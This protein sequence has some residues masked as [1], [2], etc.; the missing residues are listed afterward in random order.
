MFSGSMGLFLKAQST[1]NSLVQKVDTF[2]TMSEFYSTTE[3]SFDTSLFKL[4]GL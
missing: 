3:H 1:G 4:L 2:I